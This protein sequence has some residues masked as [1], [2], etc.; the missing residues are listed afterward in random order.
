[1]SPVEFLS[2]ELQGLT[3][4]ELLACAPHGI[5]VVDIRGVRGVEAMGAYTRHH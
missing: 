2:S 4:R 3:N 5:V 1:M